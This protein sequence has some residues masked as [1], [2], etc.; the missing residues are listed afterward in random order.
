[1]YIDAVLIETAN[2]MAKRRDGWKPV[3]A[4]VVQR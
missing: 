4:R 2:Q 3:A 1:M